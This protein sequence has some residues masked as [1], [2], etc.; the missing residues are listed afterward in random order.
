MAEE[1][2][3]ETCPWCGEEERKSQFPLCWSCNI[4]FREK[5]EE[6]ERRGDIVLVNNMEFAKAKGAETLEK[7]KKELIVANRDRDEFLPRAREQIKDELKAGG[8]FTINRQ[9]FN[10]QVVKRFE[11]LVGG[12]GRA[13][14]IWD[15]VDHHP[16]RIASIEEFL[17]P[18]EF[19]ESSEIEKAVA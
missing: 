15:F 13:D 11:Q 2:K 8:T 14:E 17:N 12:T 5:V 4:K 16:Q 7:F 19:S 6:A 18:E 10:R 9:E 1:R 3:K